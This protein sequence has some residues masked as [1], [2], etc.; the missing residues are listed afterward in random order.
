VNKLKNRSI[1]IGVFLI[2]LGILTFLGN[3]GI[4]GELIVLPLVSLAFLFI[5][6]LLGAWNKRANIGFLIPGVIVG[7]VGLYAILEAYEFIPKGAESIFLVMLGAG[8][9]I[10][11]LV[12]TMKF[13][14]AFWG[15]KYWPVM[16]GGIL[17][18]VGT[19]ALTTSVSNTAIS[20][21]TPV[22]FIM[23]GCYLLYTQLFSN[24]TKSTVAANTKN[25][26]N[27]VA[28]HTAVSN[29]K[30]NEHWKSCDITTDADV[31]ANANAD[32]DVIADI[33]NDGAPVA[34]DQKNTIN[35]S[36]N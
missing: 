34:M 11:M 1:V 4:D 28:S 18:L 26:T 7:I 17:M 29:T 13:K 20:L 14:S 30:T 16:P 12:H 23:I 27:G 31:D 15:E 32:A 2:M 19:I 33:K 21:I 10:I 22:I 36:K 25:T 35:L 5:Y 24:K 3:F 8:F 6:F 9:I